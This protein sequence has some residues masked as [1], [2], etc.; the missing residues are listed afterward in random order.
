VEL[1]DEEDGARLLV[2]VEDPLNGRLEIA[3]GRISLVHGEIE[4]GSSTEPRIQP[5]TQHS[6]A[7]HWG[8]LG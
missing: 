8:S 4:D 7:S 1:V 2:G 3:G 5:R 6:A